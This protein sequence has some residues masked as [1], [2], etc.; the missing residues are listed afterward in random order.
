MPGDVGRPASK[1][2]EDGAR[3]EG[4][5]GMVRAGMLGALTRGDTDGLGATVTLGLLRMGG[6]TGLETTGERAE[7]AL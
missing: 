6:L 3:T 7:G 5:A 4:V 2:P 1:E